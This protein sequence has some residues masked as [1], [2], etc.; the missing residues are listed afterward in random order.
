[1]CNT[2]WL[3]V[4]FDSRAA[5]M[6]WYMERQKLCTLAGLLFLIK[7]SATNIIFFSWKWHFTN[8]QCVCHWTM[9]D[10]PQYLHAIIIKEKILHL[11]LCN[12]SIWTTIIK[13][14]NPPDIFLFK[15]N[16]IHEDDLDIFINYAFSFFFFLHYELKI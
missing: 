14:K 4:L 16:Y 2:D 11:Y 13:E 1:M 15:K 8:L 9:H 5:I 12:H 7:I 3:L 10:F 6:A